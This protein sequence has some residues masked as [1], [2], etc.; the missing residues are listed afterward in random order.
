MTFKTRPDVCD[1]YQF[2]ANNARGG[3]GA[4][5]FA[6]KQFGIK[7][8]IHKASQFQ[9]DSLYAVRK[10]KALAAGL[11]WGAYHFPTP[12]SLSSQLDLFFATA[13]VDDKTFPF[14]DHETY[15]GYTMPLQEVVNFMDAV[16]QKY[17]RPCGLYSGNVIKEQMPF[18]TS[19]QRQFLKEHPFWLAQYNASPILYDYNH[20]PL[21]WTFDQGVLWQFTG[22]G[23]G[24]GPHFVPGIGSGVDVSTFITDLSDDLSVFARWWET[25]KITAAPAPLVA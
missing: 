25:G 4:D 24:P 17:G 14:L 1:M 3:D 23:A 15:R 5:F 21:P 8:I 20:H 10:P 6:A 11:M 12:A 9:R 13:G 7:A 22:D 19:G 16:D 18:A 2:N